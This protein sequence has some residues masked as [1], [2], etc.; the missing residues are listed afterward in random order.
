MALP[1]SQFIC[2]RPSRRSRPRGQFDRDHRQMAIVSLLTKGLL[3]EQ[4]DPAVVA[5]FFSGSNFVVVFFVLKGEVGVF[6]IV[7]MACW[8]KWTDGFI[9]LSCQK[10]TCRSVI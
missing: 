1:I 10:T 5:L 6:E 2:R 9:I 3:S 7:F 8:Q 4:N